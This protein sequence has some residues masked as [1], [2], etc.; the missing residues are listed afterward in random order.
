M[1]VQSTSG[2]VSGLAVL[3]GGALLVGCGGSSAP[4]EPLAQ[5]VFAGAPQAPAKRPRQGRA[6]RRLGRRARDVRRAPEWAVVIRVAVTPC[7]AQQTNPRQI[8]MVPG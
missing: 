5:G 6:P 3:A 4:P 1:G 2:V 8:D 7:L